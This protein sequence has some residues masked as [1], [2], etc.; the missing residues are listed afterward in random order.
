MDNQPSPYRGYCFP[1][2]IISYAVWLYYRFCLSFRDGEELLAER[3][4]TVSYEAVRL[5]KT[6][7]GAKRFKYKILTIVII[8]LPKA[9][10]SLLF[11]VICK[12]E[13]RG[14]SSEKRIY[15]I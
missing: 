2:E 3:G 1:P 7:L 4:A 5:D 8:S 6:I 11:F 14:C 10:Y 9:T 13:G 15:L 12:G